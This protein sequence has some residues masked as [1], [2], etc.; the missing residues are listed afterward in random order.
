MDGVRQESA[1][2]EESEAFE[3]FYRSPPELLAR[4]GDVDRMLGDVDVAAGVAPSRQRSRY[5]R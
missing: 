2:V 5:R 1:I 4:E 3:P